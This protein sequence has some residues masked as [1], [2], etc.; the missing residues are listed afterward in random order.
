MLGDDARRFDTMSHAPSSAGLRPHVFTI[1]FLALGALLRP[2]CSYADRVQVRIE[3]LDGE[4]LESAR[5]NL[6]LR[7][8]EDREVSGAQVRR[9]FARAEEQIQAALEPFGYYE[10]SVRGRLER[11]EDSAYL[12]VFEVTPGEA[13]IV[14]ESRVGVSDAA[15][16]LETIEQAITEFEPRVGERLDH[17]AYERSK[18]RIATALA[19]EGFLDAKPTRRRVEVV[20]SA[21]SAEIDLFYEAGERHRFGR[22]TYSDSQFPHEF[23][24]RFTPWKEG[25]YYSVDKLLELQQALVD[26][27]YFSSVAVTP[28]LEQRDEQVVPVDVLLVPAKRTVYTAQVYVSTDSGPGARV[29]FERRW[30]NK[31]GHKAGAEVEYSSRLQDIS[32]FY[33]IPRPGPRSRTFN[34]GVG[35][36]DEETDTS[37]SRMARAAAT[38]VT[39]RWKGFTRTLGLQYLNGDFEVA[40]ERRSTSLLYADALLT[41]RKADD[42]YFPMSGYSLLYGLRFAPESPFSDTTF[43]Q[44]RAEGKWLRQIGRNGRF[45]ARLSLGAMA[46]DDFDSLPPELRFFAGGDRSIRGFDYQEIGETNAQGGVIGGEYLAV[47]GVEYEHYFLENWGLAAFVDAGD[48]FKSSFETNAGAGLGLRWKSPVGLLRLDV[49]RPVVTDFDSSWRIHLVIGPDL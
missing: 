32:A 20:K 21:R 13:V 4:M 17:G 8:Y 3:G 33:R 37:R 28:N 45:I 5:G 36:R 31:R 27:D 46:V 42:L 38:E 18:Q 22:T 43:V 1:A 12:A 44:A 39:A 19:N 9:L 40:D 11:P 10:A 7:Q 25:E 26:A 48:A 30:I 2:E 29:G 49:A 35:Y 15:A 24:Q 34:F 23:M 47:G 14:R 16:E 41:R 6:E